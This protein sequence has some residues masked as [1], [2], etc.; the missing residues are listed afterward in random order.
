[1]S[2]GQSL[3]TLRLEKQHRPWT[4]YL[5]GCLII[6]LLLVVLFIRV[7]GTQTLPTGLFR[8]P[9]AYHYY[10]LAHL[11][12]E[13]GHLPA[14]DMHRW[15]P[16]GRDLGQTLNLYGYAFAYAYKVIASLFPNVTLYHICL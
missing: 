16:L 7:Q 15:L 2:Q 4:K 6:G 10:W 5:T 14:R 8:G 12:S 13:A 9:D 11:I 1:M 3:K